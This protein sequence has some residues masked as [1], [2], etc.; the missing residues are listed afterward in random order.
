MNFSP[1]E[2]HSVPYAPEPTRKRMYA[3]NAF[4]IFGLVVT[5]LVV[6]FRPS[7]AEA[8]LPTSATVFDRYDAT[9]GAAVKFSDLPKITSE[10]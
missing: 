9:T 3:S 2:T 8:V 5:L 4:M 10:Y 6:M 1:I 7:G